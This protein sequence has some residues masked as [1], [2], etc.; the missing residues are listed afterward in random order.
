MGPSNQPD[1]SNAPPS[2]SGTQSSN[3]VSNGSAETE[4]HQDTLVGSLTDSSLA[5]GSRMLAQ[6]DDIINTTGD[7]DVSNGAARKLYLALH[8]LRDHVGKVDIDML[9][10][11]GYDADP[12][13]EISED[14]DV[15]FSMMHK[16]GEEVLAK[17]AAVEKTVGEARPTWKMKVGS[18]TDPEKSYTVRW[19]VQHYEKEHA[20]E[21]E[22]IHEP[23]YSCTCKSFTFGSHDGEYCKHIDSI[24]QENGSDG[25]M[26]EEAKKIGKY[27]PEVSQ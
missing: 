18:F 2:P 27:I 23:H 6:I 19:D 25:Q 3:V 4:D 10:A 21:G 8:K 20:E 5:K 9:E 1:S 22:V 16:H 24:I 7:S 11:L 14:L 12:L 15:V 17:A 13:R 26:P